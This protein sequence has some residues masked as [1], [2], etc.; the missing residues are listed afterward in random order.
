MVDRDVVPSSKDIQDALDKTRDRILRWHDQVVEQDRSGSGLQSLRRRSHQG[1][2]VNELMGG[3]TDFVTLKDRYSLYPIH[4]PFTRIYY[5]PGH[6]WETDALTGV[7]FG[8]FFDDRYNKDLAAEALAMPSGRIDHLY[9]ATDLGQLFDG[10]F[11][12]VR[13]PLPTSE[14]R[15]FMQVI[16]LDFSYNP[17]LDLQTWAGILGQ[18]PIRRRQYAYYP[19]GRLKEQPDHPIHQISFDTDYDGIG[20]DYIEPK[21]E[22][23]LRPIDYT[24]FADLSRETH[25]MQFRIDPESGRPFYKTY[26]DA[27]RWL[28][29]VIDPIPHIEAFGQ[30]TPSSLLPLL[31]H[32]TS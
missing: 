13:F 8:V 32:T 21:M 27:I 29:E 17:L 30:S 3:R 22:A 23:F 24:L 25:Q 11:D 20:S 14:R 19:N 18:G 12:E 6:A 16:G 15:K 2:G 1:S 28:P 9:R 26:D 4:P 31:T 5:R 7:V 10:P